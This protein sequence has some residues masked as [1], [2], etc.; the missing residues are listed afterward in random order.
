MLMMPRSRLLQLI[1]GQAR[2]LT[3][4]VCISRIWQNTTRLRSGRCTMGS[5]FDIL[6]II[7]SAALDRRGEVLYDY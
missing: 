6:T 4:F 5:G 2:R 3:R 7:V 1:T